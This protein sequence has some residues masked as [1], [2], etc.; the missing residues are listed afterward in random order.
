MRQD[1]T[2]RPKDLWDP[3]A[4]ILH[5]TR[6]DV[7]RYP[8]RSLRVSD[9][10][11]AQYGI[12][13]DANERFDRDPAMAKFGLNTPLWAAEGVAIALA[14]QLALHL[15]RSKDRR[16]VAAASV[17]M[18]IIRSARSFVAFPADFDPAVVLPG[19]I[20]WLAEARWIRSALPR[21]I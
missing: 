12:A 4:S 11:A 2:A 16:P 13:V 3:V 19:W 21:S 14:P 15:H 17:N 5:G 7:M 1:E 18:H 6:W 10:F 9:A 8:D 20:D